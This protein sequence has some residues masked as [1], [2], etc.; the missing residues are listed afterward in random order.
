MLFDT[1]NNLSTNKYPSDLCKHPQSSPELQCLS[2]CGMCNLEIQ[3]RLIGI[4][5]PGKHFFHAIFVNPQRP[6]CT[7]LRILM[8]FLHK[9]MRKT[10]RLVAVHNILARYWLTHPPSYLNITSSVFKSKLEEKSHHDYVNLP[11]C[12]KAFFK[13]YFWA[14]FLNESVLLKLMPKY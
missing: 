11:Q 6:P 4:M 9:S 13:M 2:L 5:C 7:F 8:S 12:H 3:P 1:V 14:N 10:S